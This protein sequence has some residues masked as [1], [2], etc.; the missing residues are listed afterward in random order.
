MVSMSPPRTQGPARLFI[1]YRHTEPDMRLAHELYTRLSQHHEVFIDKKILVGADWAKQINDEIERADFLIVLLS[2]YSIH[3]EMVRGEIERA[4][5]LAGRNANRKPVILPIRVQYREGLPYPLNGY[6][7]SINWID[8]DSDEQTDQV[9]ARL[10]EAITN[11]PVAPPNPP[12]PPVIRIQPESTWTI[13]KGALHHNSP[14][15]VERSADTQVQRLIAKPG[16]VTIAIRGPRQIGKTSLLVRLAH[17]AHAH[18]KLVAWIDFQLFTKDVLASADTF[19]Q[20]FCQRIY[21]RLR[22]QLQLGSTI[23]EFWPHPINDPSSCT[24]FLKE[25]L[26]PKLG[27]PLVLAMD[28]VDRMLDSPIRSDFFGMLRTMHDARAIEEP[29]RLLDLVL[30]ASTEP[31]LW[32]PEANR[33]PFARAEPVSLDTFTDRQLEALNDSY[34]RPLQPKKVEQLMDL[35]SGHPF[36]SHYAMYAVANGDYTFDALR[37]RAAD[38]HGPFDDHLTH[39]LF[40]LFRSPELPQA[41]LRVITKN[42]CDD[43]I[44]FDRLHGAGLVIRDGNRVR[45]SNKLYKEFFRTRCGKRA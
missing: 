23:G 22:K 31:S 41:Y 27:R 10:N 11:S 35:L 16:G 44:V 9:L 3:S 33:S 24:D 20:Q 40:R 42:R 29:L 38:V 45:P 15:Y 12:S 21:D 32:I 5:D 7:A 8:W 19:Y 6:F 30:V 36:L 1:S 17:A 26:L 39:L 28:E 18:G 43:E 2:A 14:F 25:G 13:P 34:N 4:R 37:R